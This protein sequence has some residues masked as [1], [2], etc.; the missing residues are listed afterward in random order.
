MNLQKIL[1]AVDF[2]RDSEL[3]IDAALDVARADNATIT[4]LHV[5]EPLPYSTPDVGLYMP[6]PEMMADLI[7][8]AR[9]ALE[10]CKARCAAAGAKVE[11]ALVTGAPPIEIV[12]YAADHG[13][14]LIVIGSHGRRGFRRWMLGSVAEAVVRTADRPVLTTHRSEAEA[15]AAGAA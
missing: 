10:V 5:C 4:L 12:R 11:T 1:V 6:S 3:A 7:S 13:F 14:D 9:G 15:T 2:S 8:D